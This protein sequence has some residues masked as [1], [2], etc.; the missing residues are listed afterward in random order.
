M[1]CNK[2][3]VLLLALTSSTASAIPLNKTSPPSPDQQHGAALSPGRQADYDYLRGLDFLSRDELG[4]ARDAFQS[5]LSQQKDDVRAMLGLAEVAFLQQD[6]ASAGT[7]IREA[8]ALEPDNP[9]VQ[10]SYGRLLHVEGQYGEAATA[11]ARAAEL[12]PGNIAFQLDAAELF[13][14]TL[15]DHEAATRY[16]LAAIKLDDKHAGARYGY[17][18]TLLAQGSLD[19]GRRELETAALLDARNPFPFHAIADSYLGTGDQ[20]SALAYYQKAIDVDPTFERAYIAR[21]DIFMSNKDYAA[22]QSEVDKLL[23]AAPQ[24]WRGHLQQALIHHSLGQLADAETSYRKTISLN[25]ENGLAFNNLAW[26]LASAGGHHDEAESLA[27]AAVA[28]QENN[29]AFRDTLGW[30]L[31]KAGKTAGAIT[32]LEHSVELNPADINA[33][34]HLGEALKAA[35]RPAEAK[36]VYIQALEASQDQ[37]LTEEI[38]AHMA[39]L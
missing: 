20:N 34:I 8:L 24:S 21:S 1:S 35:G 23:A 12:D 4:A 27:R 28:L 2:V 29:G 13:G 16:Y 19:Q 18:V 22:A 14:N 26:L 36:E 32:E 25:K 39:G 15:R 6:I 3:W 9:F 17:G 33:R 31:L 38:K 11:I 7:Y 30:V 37:R 10:N 5:A